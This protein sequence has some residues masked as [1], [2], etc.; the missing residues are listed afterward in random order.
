MLA[1]MLYNGRVTWWL[2]AGAAALAA[3]LLW[4]RPWHLR[5]GATDE[6][7]A[8]AMLGDEIVKR[9]T[10]NATRAVTIE[11]QPAETWPW[12]VQVGCKRAG[13]YSYD[14]IDNLGT[15]SAERIVPELQNLK[16]GDTVPMSP[17]GTQGLTVKAIDSNRSMLWVSKNENCT[18]AWALYNS[19]QNHTR[20]VTR[21]RMRYRW[22]SPWM[23]FNL[24]FD[25]GDYVMMRKMLLGLKRRAECGSKESITVGGEP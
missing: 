12:L 10:F 16:I 21:V 25:P 3:Y 2:A 5:W 22:L 13:W 7:L 8:R 19:D 20:L 4:I 1:W 24:L 17:N 6:E 23:A 11:A 15:P 9:P 14:W 18:W